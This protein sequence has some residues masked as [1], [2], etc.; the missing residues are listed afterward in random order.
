MHRISTRQDKLMKELRAQTARVEKLAKAE[1]DV[2]EGRASQV[3]QFEQTVS[4]AQ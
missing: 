3:G 1:H 2:I 4:E